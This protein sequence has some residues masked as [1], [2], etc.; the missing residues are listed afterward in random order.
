[1]IRTNQF[2]AEYNMKNIDRDYDVFLVERT[3][4][5]ARTKCT[6]IL[7]L[8]TQQFRARAVQYAFGMKAL[9]LFDKEDVQEQAF[10]AAITEKYP[11]ARV[12]RLDVLNSEVCTRHFYY[13]NRALLQ[14]LA[15]SMRVPR[16][17]KFRYNN[18]TGR[19]Y[20]GRPEWTSHDRTN[21]QIYS[22]YMI[23]ISIDPGMYLNLDVKTFRRSTNARDERFYLF[24][25][26]SGAFR[27]KLREDQAP[28]SEW[29]AE[30]G[31]K[32]SHNTVPY[33]RINDYESYHASKLGV[34]AQFLED[35]KRYLGDYVT[36][37]AVTREEDGCCR[38]S[39]KEREGVT[40]A[41]LA[42]L[43]R[44][45][46]VH[47]VDEVQT[48]ASA[49]L[50]DRV[51]AEL[52]EIYGIEATRGE[53]HAERYNIRL[54]HDLTYYKEHPDARDPHNE[55][56]VRGCV[57]QHMT[58]EEN[59]ELAESDVGKRSPVIRRVLTELI[60]K[61]DVW[62]GWVSIY[63]WRRL[64]AG[65]TWTFVQREWIKESA[66]ETD[67]KRKGRYLYTTVQIDP[68]GAMTFRQFDDTA[69]ATDRFEERIRYVYDTYAAAQRGSRKEIE[70]LVF[71]DILNIHVILRTREQ[72]L[73]N[74]EAIGA[75]LQE[76]NRKE[77]VPRDRFEQALDTF[78][79]LGAEESAYAER[80]RLDLPPES[81]V[82]KDTLRKV[83]NMRQAMAS[84]LNRYL[85]AQ[86][87]M[88]ISPE[89]K[90]ADHRDTYMLNNITDIRYYINHETDGEP[91]LVSLNYYAGMDWDD[92][93]WSAP[94][95]SACVVRQVQAEG[96]L[97]F[98]EL[99]P[100][101]AVDFVRIGQYTVLPFPFKYLREYRQG[102]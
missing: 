38:E 13:Q 68:C 49:R 25:P 93:K 30:S 54:I 28:Q 26:V 47:I 102:T 100:L 5:L 63:D 88:W 56:V 61:G 7:D 22:L 43:L 66:T 57:V 90:T 1:M 96:E 70:G 53:L 85:Q 77:R 60:I 51:A 74:I 14:L 83:M 76:T 6:N 16:S 15:N 78:A 3:V 17:D 24:D 94:V 92:L 9:V 80:V 82:T 46:G 18:L 39:R 27:R 84:R 41:D 97:A 23:R 71:S 34:M 73:P 65:R 59:A 40:D 33:L 11:D 36:L 91:G 42:S 52:R 12:E 58:L 101:L 37:T 19:L 31:F 69:V 45:K 95:R 44:D 32:N 4:D 10:R 20:Y 29:F 35:V 62:R 89:W 75:A 87:G 2:H 55:D 86:Y 21:G 99:L 50:A 81:F 72:T 48:D 67:S 98:E 64:G 8:A 79:A